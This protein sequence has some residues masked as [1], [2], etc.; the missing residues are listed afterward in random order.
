MVV[1]GK[2]KAQDFPG[3]PEAKTPRFQSRWPGFKP[4]PGNEIPCVSTKT[5]CREINKYKNNVEKAHQ[6]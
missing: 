4:W 6:F 5:R 2:E 1:Q 3:G